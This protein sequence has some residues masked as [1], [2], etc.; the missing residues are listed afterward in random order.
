MEE[1][2]SY[3]DSCDESDAEA[4]RLMRLAPRT[5]EDEL[6]DCHSIA[7]SENLSEHGEEQAEQVSHRVLLHLTRP[8]GETAWLEGSEEVHLPVCRSDLP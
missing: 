2:P 7:P 3:L 6:E 8:A 1:E 5:E 4:V